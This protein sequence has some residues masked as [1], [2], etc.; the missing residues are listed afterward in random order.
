M[1]QAAKWHQRHVQGREFGQLEKLVLIHF[2]N[3][4]LVKM[5]AVQ[6]PPML[7]SNMDKTRTRDRLCMLTTVRQQPSALAPPPSLLL[8]EE[9]G[10]SH[11]F[12]AGKGC[13]RKDNLA[14]TPS[15]PHR[16]RVKRR[17]GHA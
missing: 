15:T 7:I 3:V 16:H 2:R 17:K 11:P 6:T 10:P 14:R 4:V 9:H 8:A 13:T 1:R 5:P 12:T